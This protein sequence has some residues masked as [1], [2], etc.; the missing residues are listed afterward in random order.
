MASNDA[1]GPVTR[2]LLLRHAETAE[3]GRFHGAESDVGLSARG[4]LQA[5]AVARELAEWK[6]TA[7]YASAMRRALDTAA[8]IARACGLEPRV[9]ESLHERRMGPL[10]GVLRAEGLAVYEEA[11]RR[12]RAGDL[13][14]THQGG[15]SYQDIRDRVVPAFRD[16]AGRHA[17]ATIVVVAHGIVIRVLLTTLLEGYGPHDFDRVGIAN[18]G[19]NALRWQGGRWRAEALCRDAAG[20]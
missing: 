19:I 8:P 3:P 12:W 15:E 14:H 11:K 18:C 9:V 2:V 1:D 13:R 6:P 10:A 4:R 7:L 20:W 17:G 16:V 5:E